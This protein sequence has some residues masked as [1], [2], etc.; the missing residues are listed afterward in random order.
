MSYWTSRRMRDRFSTTE[1]RL[2]SNLGAILKNERTKEVFP[3]E[4]EER[5]N[6]IMGKWVKVIFA[7]SIGIDESA[8]PEPLKERATA[9]ADCALQAALDGREFD[10]F[11]TL[12]ALY[13]LFLEELQLQ[14]I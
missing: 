4:L 7:V 2:L 3:E 10:I 9:M 12:K 13:G 5:R 1:K 8:L 11:P 14:D 6:R